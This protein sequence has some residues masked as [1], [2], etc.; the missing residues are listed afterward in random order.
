M[1]SQDWDSMIEASKVTSEV[2]C[3]SKGNSKTE[4]TLELFEVIER[5]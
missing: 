2:G 3:S 4:I 5:C 1:E